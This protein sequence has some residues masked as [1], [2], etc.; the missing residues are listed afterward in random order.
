LIRPWPPGGPRVVWTRRLVESYGIGSVSR[1]KYYQF[2]SDRGNAVLLCLDS[3]TGDELW[4]FTYPSVY[5]DFYGYNSGPRCSPVID[6]GRVYLYG[7]EGML[8][9]VDVETGKKV[10]AVDVNKRFGVVQNFFGVGST[11][12]VFKDLLIVMVGGSPPDDQNIPPGRLDLVRGNGSGIVAFDKQSGEVRYQIT[13]ELASYS[14]PKLAFHDGRPWCFVFARRGLV[15]FNPETG[16]VDFQYPWRAKIL[17]SV[18]ASVPVVVGDR[19]FL[20]ETYGPGSVLL[21][22]RSGGFGEIW[23]D[24]PNA[25]AKAMQTHWNTPIYHEGY[26]YGSSGRH[27]YNAELRCIEFETGKIQW[28]VPGLSRCSL[29]YIDKHFVCLGEDGAL[30]LIRVNPKKYDLVSEVVLRD[31]TANVDPEW[32]EQL[33]D[34]A[35]R[36]LRRP[37]WA[38]PIISHGLMYVRGKDRVAC[39]E[40]IPPGE[41]QIGANPIK[42]DAG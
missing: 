38:A 20:S 18:N 11:P 2:D 1:G 8:H 12:V 26:L 37:A 23:K 10:W 28:S 32:P 39:L 13:D 40:L 24:N 25:R 36:L 33:V 31:R 22:F 4:R 5:T 21:S 34:E 42:N 17:E 3:R 27:E 16:K 7:V 6:D 30:R 35:T 14:S 15:A 41:P 29:V 9:C 19:V